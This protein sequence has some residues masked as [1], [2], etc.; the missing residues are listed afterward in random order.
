MPQKLIYN[1]S[2]WFYFVISTKTHKKPVYKNE[3]KPFHEMLKEK[4]VLKVET[5]L[6]KS[7]ENVEPILLWFLR[8]ITQS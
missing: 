6:Y 7:V 2:S 5:N 1:F 8:I 4:S 3:K